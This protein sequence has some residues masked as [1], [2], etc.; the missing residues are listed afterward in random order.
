MADLAVLSRKMVLHGHILPPTVN[1]TLDSVDFN[2]MIGS[3]P[4]SSEV[5][6]NEEDLVFVL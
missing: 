2:N 1:G 3:G 5:V 6:T 4:A